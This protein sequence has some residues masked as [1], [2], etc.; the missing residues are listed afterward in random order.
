MYMRFTIL[1]FLSCS[2][3]TRGPNGQLTR[4]GR[5]RSSWHDLGSFF[6]QKEG[7]PLE[8]ADGKDNSAENKETNVCAYTSVNF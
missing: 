7:P 3:E 1:Q 8:S 2:S 5:R 4:E 6:R